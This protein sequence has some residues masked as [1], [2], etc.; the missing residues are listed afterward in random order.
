MMLTV[1][2]M[3]YRLRCDVLIIPLI[4]H[5]DNRAL[6]SLL[7]LPPRLTEL[8]ILLDRVDFFLFLLANLQLAQVL[9]E[10]CCIIHSAIILHF[11][12]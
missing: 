8:D 10:G 7:H 3:W 1:D 11:F 2:M 9:F 12:T 5:R 6:G 4:H